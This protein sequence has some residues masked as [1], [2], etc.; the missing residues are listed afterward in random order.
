MIDFPYT[1]APLSR[2]ITRSVACKLK[3]PLLGIVVTRR[4]AWHLVIDF[5]Y[6]LAP[7]P[8]P[9]TRSVAC[10]L[11]DPLLGIV[12]T[13]RDAWHAED[14]YGGGELLKWQ[15]GQIFVLRTINWYLARNYLD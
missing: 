6:T 9:I 13:R 11:K 1:L 4:D 12:V 3:D 2:P 5:P 8:R 15:F 14:R 7:L 10:K